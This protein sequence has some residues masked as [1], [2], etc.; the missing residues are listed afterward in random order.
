MSELK[1]P[2]LP[3]GTYRVTS[4][5]NDGQRPSRPRQGPGLPE[6]PW[7]QCLPPKP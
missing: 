4:E 2:P 7:P 3:A 5:F 1:N 6:G